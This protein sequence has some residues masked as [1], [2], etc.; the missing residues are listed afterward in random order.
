[1]AEVQSWLREGAAQPQASASR[2]ITPALFV[3]GFCRATRLGQF[4]AAIMVVLFVLYIAFFRTLA[5]TASA[6]IEAPISSAAN[7]QSR[8]QV[9]ARFAGVDAT[10]DSN[11]FGKFMQIMGSVRLAEQIERDHHIS[12]LVFPGW[13]ETTQTWEAPQ[14]P[15]AAIKRFVKPLLGTPSWKQPDAS[16][17]AQYLRLHTTV[18]LVPSK[19]PFDLRSQVFTVS[20]KDRNPQMAYNL[21]TWTLQSAD[22]IVRSDQLSRTNNRITYLKGL[23]AHAQELY[24][25]ENLQEILMS[26]E[27]TL[28]MLRSD[29]NFAID[30]IDPPHVPSQPEGM[31]TVRLFMIFAFLG[32]IIYAAAVFWILLKR[33]GQSN[34]SD[35]LEAPFPDPIRHIYAVVSNRR[36]G[37]VRKPTKP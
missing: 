28:M 27:Q 10:G 24:L 3:E 26:E 12:R 32:G 13:N 17:L 7:S 31:S 6:V 33:T 2:A 34:D 35:P 15:I 22:G 30:L 9:L 14:G 36:S 18:S 21:L 4:I 20:V 16:Q 11:Q 5:Y 25:K 19:S 37:G 8:A 29:R 23:I 1:M